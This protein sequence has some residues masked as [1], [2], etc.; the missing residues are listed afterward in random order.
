KRTALRSTPAPVRRTAAAID[1][2]RRLLAT[3]APRTFSEKLHY[4]MLR[5]HRALLTTFSDKVAV[6]EYVRE[7]LGRVDLLPTLHAV[8]ER[9]GD[10]DP[11]ALPREFVLKA[12]HASGGVVVVS[13]TADPQATL[14]D[15]RANWPA[16]AIHPDRL[17]WAHLRALGDAWLARR[18]G[19]GP[20]REWGYVHVPPRLVVEE[21]LRTPA[22]AIPDDYK[23]FVFHGRCRLVQVDIDRYGAHRQ[24]FFLPDWTPLD[25]E[26]YAPR[27]AVPPPPPAG[28]AEMLAIADRLGADTDFVRVDLYD[29]ADRVV[30]GE[31]TSYVLG[32]RFSFR[33]PTF[34]AEVG[35]WWNPPRRY[36]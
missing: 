9:A 6:R 19:G 28:L 14:P 16:A 10:L 20:Y 4:K 23:L 25:V 33:P 35:S 21:L 34:D 36:R 13:E 2:R 1:Y 15:L 24:Q 8:V 22:G 7:R 3:R 29:L 26:L 27:A 18:Y 31:L 30:F 32:G 17:D 12:A 11:D 5:D